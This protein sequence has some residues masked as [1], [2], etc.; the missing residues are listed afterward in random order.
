MDVIV[1]LDGTLC[2][3][4]HRL[5]HIKGEKKDWDTFFAACL[6][7]KPIPRIIRLVQAL[8]AYQGG[9]IIF[10][11]GRSDAVEGETKQW[12]WEVGLHDAGGLLGRLYMRKAGDHR[13]DHEVKLEMLAK[14]R[15][16][17][18]NPV[19]AIEDRTQVVKMWRAQGLTCLQ[20]TDGDF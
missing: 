17:G 2:D 6:Y 20:V 8:H 4:T 13:P 12:L 18:Y 5:H 10:C 1:D 11:T 9:G 19:M 7:D 15:E 14:M 3:I 16:D